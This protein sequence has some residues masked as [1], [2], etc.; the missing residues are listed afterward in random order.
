M[1]KDFSANDAPALTWSAGWY[2][3]YDR[4]GERWWDGREW[5]KWRPGDREDRRCGADARGGKSEQD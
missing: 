2:P 4:G 3:D 5:G 1:G